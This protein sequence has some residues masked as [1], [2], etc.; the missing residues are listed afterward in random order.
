MLPADQFLVFLRE[1]TPFVIWLWLLSSIAGLGYA[2][3]LWFR[4]LADV[5]RQ[6]Q[7]PTTVALTYV[8]WSNR[9]RVE[10][11]VWMFAGFVVVGLCSA[12][13]TVVPSGL[14]RAGV[15][16][17]YILTFLFVNLLTAFNSY[18]DEKRDRV[19]Q[20]LLQRD[21]RKKEADVSSR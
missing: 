7:R 11:R 17:L 8:A 9:K 16:L 12:A 1:A 15:Q 5:Q 13:L 10:V 20:A 2:L 18:R 4:S 14:L 3:R 6:Y 21:E 19:L